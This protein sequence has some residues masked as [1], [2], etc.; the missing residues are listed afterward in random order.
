M[1]IKELSEVPPHELTS[2]YITH[3][4][5]LV[6]LP[7]T[8]TGSK[9]I[10]GTEAAQVATTMVNYQHWQLPIGKHD[11]PNVI[12]PVNFASH[13]GQGM[14][15]SV[16]TDVAALQPILARNT[17][18][19][20]R[21]VSGDFLFS[22]DFL[23]AKR[24]QT[25]SFNIVSDDYG[26]QRSIDSE[27]FPIYHRAAYWYR[28]AEV[29]PEIKSAFQDGS[30]EKLSNTIKEVTRTNQVSQVVTVLSLT[31]A[32]LEKNYLKLVDRSSDGKIL[33]FCG[34]LNAI[35]F[36]PI[37]ASTNPNLPSCKLA[38]VSFHE[39]LKSPQII[40]RG[41]V[42]NCSNPLTLAASAEFGEWSPA[43]ISTINKYL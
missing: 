29:L 3:L 21:E 34:A 11:N 41:L 6:W 9:R 20:A 13:N 24:N 30:I 40:Q 1:T 10:Y 31:E 33:V 12:A 22:D 27:T 5:N 2:E 36:K 4:L 32:K 18:A 25:L 16:A 35:Y 15:L 14:A 28:L 39:L 17:Y 42:W 38:N 26:P 23:N 19:V 37:L 8:T 7:T 43:N